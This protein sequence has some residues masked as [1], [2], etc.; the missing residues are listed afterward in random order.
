MAK[1]NGTDD[2]ADPPLMSIRAY[3]RA[4][5]ASEAT[6]RHA[7]RKGIITPVRGKV[8]PAQADASWGQIR[9]GRYNEGAS[10]I[11]RAKA[12]LELQRDQL[13]R[14]SQKYASRAEAIAEYEREAAF[15]LDALRKMPAQ[16]AAHVAE[17]LSI[18]TEK[19]R[20]LLDDFAEM[21]RQD[22]GDL[23]RRLVNVV[24][25]A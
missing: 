8:D 21:C 17:Q 4:R 16:E 14:L 9:R 19:A 6:I 15:V 2:A 20:R 22:L 11:R 5:D 3:G 13:D 10:K 12:R 24:H 25:R 18:S 7:I 1:S 23:R